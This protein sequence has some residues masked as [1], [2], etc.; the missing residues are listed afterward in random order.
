M[1]GMHALLRKRRLRI[2]DE[3][4]R[5]E[6]CHSILD[7]RSSILDPLRSIA[8]RRQTFMLRVVEVRASRRF[9]PI[10][11]EAGIAYLLQPDARSVEAYDGVLSDEI[12][13]V[14]TVLLSRAMTI[15]VSQM[16]E[17]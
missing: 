4:L 5:T 14:T 10:L 15:L 8:R 3:K 17:Q 1:N 2:E 13:E 16:S 6:H 9:A 12:E 7:P 11:L